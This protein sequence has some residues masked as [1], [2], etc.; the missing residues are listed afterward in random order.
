MNNGVRILFRFLS[1]KGQRRL[2]LS[3]FFAVLSAA[4]SL[5]PMLGLYLILSVILGGRDFNECLPGICVSLSGIFLQ[6]LFH[7]VSTRLSHRTAFDALYEIRSRILQK[8]SRVNQG[9]LDEN[10]AGKLKSM[11]FDDVEQFEMFYGHHFPE[12]LGG[13]F[14]PI[15]MGICM[16]VLDIRIALTLFLPVAVFV[17]CLRSM[18]KMQNKNFPGMFQTSQAMNT[19]MV[20]FIHGIKE[21]RIF[22]VE[23]QTY[24]RFEQAAKDYRQFMV[25]WFRDSRHLMTIN[26][27]VMSSGIVFVFP[28]AGYLYLQGAFDL[29]RLLLYLFIALCFVAPLSKTAIYAHMLHLNAQIAERLNALLML[30]ELDAPE[31]F[32]ELKNHSLT[33]ENVSFAYGEKEVLHGISFQAEENTVTAL[34][35]PS[36]SGKSTIAKLIDRFWDVKDG[37]IRIGGVDIREL[38]RK[39]LAKTVSFVTQDISLF[40]MSVR[41]N[42]QLGNPKASFDEVVKAAEAACCHNFIMDLPEGYD[43]KLGKGTLLSGGEKQR[44]SLARAILKNAPVLVLDE[45]TAYCDP[46][47]EAEMQKALSALA[48]GKTVIVIA[49]RL[50]SVTDADQILLIKDGRLEACG[51]HEDLL[52]QSAAY[53]NMWRAFAL[54]EQWFAGRKE[55]V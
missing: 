26:T 5:L 32:K 55:Y 33:L 24:F 6:V 7:T 1:P 39:Q 16:I 10:P 38:P 14:V 50:S 51:T 18:G 17:L 4:F 48:K 35:G 42:I 8:L 52:D 31:D 23:E 34:V 12:I 22:S 53:F 45:A 19:A 3:G 9:Y 37:M 49:H 21:L 46:D 29:S 27:V 43:T 20:E 30:P 2:C 11:L 13:L 25:K 36:G 41:E 47:N 40:E 28:A 44:I 15:I 54:S